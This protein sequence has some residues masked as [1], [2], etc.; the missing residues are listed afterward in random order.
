MQNTYTPTNARKNF[1]SLLKQVAT[2]KKPVTIQQKDPDLDAV[3]VN[4]KDWDSIQETLYLF[5]TGTL[6]K[7]VE[8]EKD[9]SGS[10]N[11]DEIDWDTL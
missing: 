2:E 7:V 11:V 4:K 3:I 10:T 9:D 8:R 6:E 1:F 5:T